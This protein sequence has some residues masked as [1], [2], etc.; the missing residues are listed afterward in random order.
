M[1]RTLEELM[2]DCD[3]SVDWTAEELEWVNAPSVGRERVWLEESNDTRE[4][5]PFCGVKH[6]RCV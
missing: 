6:P 4:E 5:C 1:G 3:L 2:E